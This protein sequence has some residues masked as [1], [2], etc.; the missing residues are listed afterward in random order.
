MASMRRAASEQARNPL[1]TEEAHDR[2]R[3]SVTRCYDEG[4]CPDD[5]HVGEVVEDAKGKR[6]VVNEMVNEVKEQFLKERTIIVIF[7]GE[8][9]N[10]ARSVKEDLMRAFEDGWTV[11]RLFHPEARRGRV[12][13]EGPNVASY[14]AKAKEI[15]DWL[16][17]QGEMKIKLEQKD[18][19]MLFKPRLSKQE[20]QDAHIQEVETKFWI[21]ALRVPLEAYYYLKSAV[22]GVFGEV[23]AEHSPEYDRDRPKLMNVKFVMAP[24][25]RPRVDD[26]L[27][28]QSPQGERWTVEIVS[29]YTDWCRRCKWYYHTENNCPRRQREEGR[30]PNGERQGGH[31]AWYREFILNQRRTEDPASE[32]AR[33][34][35]GDGQAQR[36]SA[37]PAP[38]Q[39]QEHSHHQESCLQSNQGAA[40]PSFHHH[41]PNV[42]FQGGYSRDPVHDLHG[43]PQQCLQGIGPNG[44]GFQEM[45]VQGPPQRWGTKQGWDGDNGRAAGL[46]LIPP[47]QPREDWPGGNGAL[48]HVG[49]EE[50]VFMT[51][52]E[53]LTQTVKTMAKGKSPGVDGLTM[54]FYVAN[55]VIFG[56]HLVELYNQILVGGRLGKGMTQ[57]VIALLFKKGDK[58]DIR[59]WRPISLNVSYKILAKALA[60]R[61]AKYLPKL[62]E[63]D[64]GTF[65][66]GRSIF[67]NIVI[68]IETLEVVQEK[69]LDM[70]ILLLDLEKAYDKVGWT[71]VFTTLRR[72]GFGEGFCAWIKAMY[73]FSTSA[74][75]VNGHMSESFALSRSLRQGCPLAPLIFVLQ[76]EVLLNKIRKHPDIRGLQLHNGEVC[77]VKALADDIFAISENSVSSLSALKSVMRDYSTL[78]EATVNWNKS[79]Y[80]LPAQFTLEVEWGMRR[81]ERGEEERFLGVLISLQIEESS[82]GLLLQQQEGETE[83]EVSAIV[84]DN[85]SGMVKAGFAGEEAPRVVFPSVVVQSKDGTEESFRVGM[86]LKSIFAESSDEAQSEQG[87]IELQY[88]IK[89]GIVTDFDLMEKIWRHT[90]YD[91]LHVEPQDHPVLLTESPLNPRAHR[92]KMI[93]IMFETFSVP[94]AYMSIQAVLSLY[95]T[96]RMTGIVVDCGDGVTHTAP[97]FEGYSLP[98]AVL[99]LNIGGR[100]LTDYMRTML[101][102]RGYS[103]NSRLEFEIARA[104]KEKLCYVALD[105]QREQDPAEEKLGQSHRGESSSAEKTYEL[106]DGNVVSIGSERFR[107]P[108]A[109]FN[110]SLIGMECPG[111]H[112]TTFTSIT[113][114]DVDIK[115]VMYENVLLTGGSTMFPGMLE[116]ISKELTSML[117][118]TSTI[119]E[120][121]VDAPANRK[122]S[123]WVGGSVLASLNTFQ[124]LWITEEEYRESGPSIVHRRCV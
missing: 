30:R 88:P 106:P 64:Q 122:Y 41:E 119:K 123:V 101:A 75:M 94:A 92:E 35:G 16:L 42:S 8:A 98:H 67:N 49:N 80:L 36:P 115:R 33:V 51:V 78:S 3:A 34:R 72:M 46:S 109:L 13:F 105:F 76:L 93:E 99:R 65:V 54:E 55:W 27:V 110:P 50:W 112:K 124:H 45:A 84:C 103:F 15:A 1:T 107:C 28:I 10:L 62:V 77:K 57:G 91:E 18:Y 6:F 70:A 121:K 60:H 43:D 95:S 68:A 79:T 11:R 59:N 74:V 39:R 58:T 24:E 120:V 86:D 32:E 73:T 29:P 89:N 38:M 53:E 21:T 102:D 63:G 25:S 2:V 4:V 104:I 100:D 5:L 87:G 19:L 7:Q 23:I 20:L 114:C 31:R 22:R 81:V 69:N 82:Q 44:A 113:K 117:P 9:R 66:Q 96:C 85:G 90:F 111:I 17:Q 14:V 47:W 40:A 116:R 61:L 83:V 52:L 97:I 26:E 56:P 108:E 37:Q 48:L 71:F 12:K 118:S